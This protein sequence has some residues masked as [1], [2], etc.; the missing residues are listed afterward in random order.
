MGDILLKDF[1]SCD[2]D[3]TATYRTRWCAHFRNKYEGNVDTTRLN[4]HEQSQYRSYTARCKAKALKVEKSPEEK[5]KERVLLC[6]QLHSQFGGDGP[7][8]F[9]R[10]EKALY[11]QYAASCLAPQVS[12]GE[13]KKKKEEEEEKKKKNAQIEKWCFRAKARYHIEPGKSLGSLP[14]DK[15][16]MYL[17]AKCYRFL[18]APDPLAG[19]G[20]FDCIPKLLGSATGEAGA[21]AGAEAKT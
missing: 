3:P 12:P 4:A 21:E 9:K 14:Q 10:S 19:H 17:A 6:N 8:V 2:G 15:H 18:C 7:K 16:T 20:K 13:V 1:V 5:E 11:M